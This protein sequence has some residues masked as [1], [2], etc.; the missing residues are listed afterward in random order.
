MAAM[1][2]AD[3]GYETRV[4]SEQEV[5]TL[6]QWGINEGWNQSPSDG[7]LLHRL[8]GRCCYAGCLSG[9]HV[10][11]MFASQY[12][13]LAGS[14]SPAHFAWISFYIVTPDARGKR[15]GKRLWDYAVSR[16]PK[17]CVVGLTA[18]AAEVETYKRVGFV[19]A[20]K[21]VL[22]ELPCCDA[23][24]A[25]A[26]QQQCQRQAAGVRV[27]PAGDVDFGAVVAYDAAVVPLERSAVVRG[28]ALHAGHTCVVACA[29]GGAVCGYAV[30]RS[31]VRG[32]RVAP[33]YADSA[34]VAAALLLEV[35]R[36]AGCEQSPLG[37]SVAAPECNAMAGG[38]AEGIGMKATMTCSRMYLGGAQPRY[39]AARVFSVTRGAIGL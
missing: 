8:L 29:P 5:C 11:G 23:A 37:L 27:V 34:D 12:G 36:R 22:Y 38:L 26:Q 7:P 14:P 20:H 10:A 3:D 30:A 17:G 32:L 18:V 24:R 25:L 4:A 16:L 1:E 39:D 21:D 33:M 6:V 9:R 28:W 19:Y 13:P 35:V 15:Y 2:H 31:S